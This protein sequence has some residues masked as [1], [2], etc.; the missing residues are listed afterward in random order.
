[1]LERTEM[2]WNHDF[3]VAL[4]RKEEKKTKEMN[5]LTIE[6]VVTLSLGQNYETVTIE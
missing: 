4:E 6:T 5:S 1:M 2:Y 3:C